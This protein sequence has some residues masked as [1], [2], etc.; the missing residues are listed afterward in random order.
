MVSAVARLERV[1][2]VET[3]AGVSLEPRD[4]A[5]LTNAQARAAEAVLAMQTVEDKRRESQLRR[6][7]LR[8]QI[9]AAREGTSTGDVV[10]VVRTAGDR[11][12]VD[13][14]PTAE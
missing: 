12:S 9:S 3:D 8:A 7:L 1:M 11:P 13:A 2:T 6:Q 4:L 10:V 14:D 5:A